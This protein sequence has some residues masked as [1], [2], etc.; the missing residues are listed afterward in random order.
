MKIR[1]LPFLSVVM[2]LASPA[3]AADDNVAAKFG[4]GIANL[5]TGWIEAPKNIANESRR[6]NPV[7][8]LTWGAIKGAAH[9]VGRTAVGAFDTATFFVPGRSLVHATYVWNDLN[10]ETTYGAR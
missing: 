7:V 10:H 8:G 9:T 3:F 5:T 4:R 2:L 1:L 6:H